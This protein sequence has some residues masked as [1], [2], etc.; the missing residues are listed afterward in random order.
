ME[1]EDNQDPGQ[2]FNLD[3]YRNI[4]ERLQMSK[5]NQERLNKKLPGSE[6]QPIV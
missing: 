3:N 6:Q 4:L 2:E 1:P 5:R